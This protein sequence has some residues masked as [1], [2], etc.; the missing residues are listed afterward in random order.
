MSMNI[1]ICDDEKRIREYILQLIKNQCADCHVDLFD[2]G[3]SLLAV[4]KSYDIYFLDIQMPSINGIQTAEQLRKNQEAHSLHERV[5]IFVTALK[6][7]MEDAFD[8]KAFHYLTKPINETKFNAVFARAVSDY[9]KM[10]SIAKNHII[11]KNGNIHRKLCIKDMLYVES[12]NKKVIINLVDEVLEYCGT[13]QELEDMLGNTFFRCHRCYLV[14]MNYVARYNPDTIWLEN[15]IE[16]LLAQKKYRQ[17]VKIFM[18][19]TR[20]GGSIHE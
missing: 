9:Q 8:V 20:S 1:A 7:Y 5:I 2:S 15:G 6:E 11:I 19:F 13:M 10:K 16:I 12:Q 17:F 18:M 14:N 4:D 3:N